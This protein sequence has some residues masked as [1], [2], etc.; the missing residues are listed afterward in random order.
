MQD[1]NVVCAFPLFAVPKPDG[2]VRPILDLSQWTPYINTPKFSLLDAGAALRSIQPNSY[3]VKIDLKSGFFQ[4]GITL[5]TQKFIGIYYRGTKY[6]M[7]RLPMGHALAPAIFQRFSLAILDHIKNETGVTS[8][9][10]LDD[11]LLHHTNP[12]DIQRAISLIDD[13]G[14]TINW[15]KSILIPTNKLTYLGFIVDTSHHTIKLTLQAY[16][17][18][19]YLLRFVRK[20]SEKDRQRIAGYASWILFNLR[21]P[22]FLTLDILRGDPSWITAAIKDLSILKE[23]HLQDAPMT[24]ELFSDATPNSVAAIIPA[25][26][27]SW[28]QAFESPTEINEAETVAGIMGLIWAA[29]ELRDTHLILHTDNA[30]AFCALRSGRGRTM[31]KYYIRRLFLSMLHSLGT[32]TYEVRDVQGSANPADAPSR[33]VLRTLHAAPAREEAGLLPTLQDGWR[34]ADPYHHL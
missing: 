30:S 10:Y 20:G 18:L 7:T 23:R 13:L 2:T 3:L 11:W 19:V 21:W 31:R 24:L 28:A 1:N 25:L 14:I 17:R 4:L 26:N 32:N 22:S 16:D 6:R 29:E 15:T 9:A 12:E 27:I 8:I 5:R 33:D 34:V